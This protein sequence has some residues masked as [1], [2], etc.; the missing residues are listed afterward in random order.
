MLQSF[1][2]IAATRGFNLN[3]SWTPPPHSSYPFHY[4]QIRSSCFS[5][6]F[7]SLVVLVLGDESGFFWE[8]K[9]HL[10]NEYENRITNFALESFF[11]ARN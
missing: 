8:E 1:L 2:R 6:N 10:M 9:M 5:A 4:V 7:F 11:E 3:S